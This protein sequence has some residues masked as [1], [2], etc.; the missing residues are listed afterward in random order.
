MIYT[1][2]L[3]PAVDRELTVPTIE[4]DSVLRASAWRVDYGGKGF[5]VSRMLRALGSDSVALGFAGGRSGE[6]LRDGLESLGIGTDFVWVAGETRTN[7]SIVTEA[8][9][10]YVK[11]NEP[12][13]TI[14]PAEEIALV[15][16]VRQLAKAGDWWVLAGSL[17]PGVPAS[18]YMQLIGDIQA[19]GAW[20]ILDSSG[21][22]LRDGCAARP[23]LAKPN[24][25]EIHKLTGLP[26]GNM[27]EIAAAAQAMQRSGVDNVIVS[28]GKKG[29]LLADAESVWLA[30]SPQIE[31]KNPIGA[32]DSMVGGLVWGLS[33]GLPL[34]QA[35]RWGIACGAATA[36]MSGTAVGDRELVESLA[37][38]VNVSR[39]PLSAIPQP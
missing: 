38:Q 6:L 23:F 39:E 27:A 25:V 24:D 8:H 34:P 9:D 22:A 18:I 4:F 29:A 32:G 30:A 35:L 36:S 19:A 28:L 10:H 26:V 20:V 5:N 16:K 17:P 33:Q 2:T 37:A 31:E 12:G 15:R 13:P 21:D 1:V 7:V 14:S 3:N 11:A